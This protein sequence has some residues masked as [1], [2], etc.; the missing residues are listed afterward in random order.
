[1]SPIYAGPERREGGGQFIA[2]IADLRARMTNVESGLRDQHSDIKCILKTLNEARGGWK[3]M[4]VMGTIAGAAG[5]F[6][7]KLGAFAQLIR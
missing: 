6:I 5:A 3:G 2:D 1:M 7:A 4:V